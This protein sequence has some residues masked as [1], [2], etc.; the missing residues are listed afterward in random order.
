MICPEAERFARIEDKL[1][2]ILKTMDGNGSPSLPVRLDRLEAFRAGW[3]RVFWIVATS[4]V[5]AAVTG[6][7]A[8]VI[9]L[10][11]TGGGK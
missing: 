6:V 5:G 9:T 7:L 2:R 8:L 4:A 11:R 10:I 3:C 1:D